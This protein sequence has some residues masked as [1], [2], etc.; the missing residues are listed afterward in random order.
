[1]KP[2]SYTTVLRVGSLQSY[3]WCNDQIPMYFNLGNG[4]HPMD[5]LPTQIMYVGEPM[6]F[7][8]VCCMLTVTI[9]FTWGLEGRH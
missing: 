3:S 8:S 9:D 5:L 4:H 2:S 6:S 1:M 7:I